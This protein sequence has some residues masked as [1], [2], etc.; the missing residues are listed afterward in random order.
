MPTD[1]Q[2]TGP[3]SDAFEC[4][5]HDPRKR[6]SAPKSDRAEVSE[7]KKELQRLRAKVAILTRARD[8]WKRLADRYFK[9]K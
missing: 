6:V 3:F 2:C 4:P 9:E 5:V 7:Q 1:P 8:H